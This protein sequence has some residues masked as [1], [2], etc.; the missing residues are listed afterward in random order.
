MR[1]LN[2]IVFINSAHVPYA[3]VKLDGNVHFIGTQGV[4]K[5]TLLRAVLFFYNADKGKLGIRTQDKQLGYDEFYLPYSNSYIIYEI[6]RENGKFFIISFRSQGR[7]A[8]RIVDCEYDKQFFV[9]DTGMVRE[10]WRE[11]RQRI[12]TITF[13]SDVIRSYE[14]FR[15]IIFGNTRNV[16]PEYRRF[17]ILES[18]RYQNIVRA[19]TNIFLNQSLESRVIKDTIIDS[20]DFADDYIDLE[21]YRERIKEFRN[22]YEDIWK[23]YKKEKDGSIKVRDQADNAIAEYVK[24]E[25]LRRDIDEL[26]GQ[27]L[28][29]LRRDDQELPKIKEEETALNEKLSSLRQRREEESKRHEGERDKLNQTEGKLKDFIKRL[30]EK[31]RHYAN[32]RI[33]EIITRIN[34]E[35]E[36]K[37]KNESLNNQLN[38]LTSANRGITDKYNAMI[39]EAETQLKGQINDTD[40]RFNEDLSSLNSKK[41]RLSEEYNALVQNIRDRKDEV[42]SLIQ[43]ELDTAREA[44]NELKMKETEILNSNPYKEEGAEIASKIDELKARDYELTRILAQTQREIDRIKHEA[45]IH[46][47]DLSANCEREVVELEKEIARWQTDIN[48][49]ND[50]LKN[51]EGSLMEWLCDNAPGWEENIGLLLDEEAV[52]Y[53]PDLK[54]HRIDNSCTVY[55][56]QLDLSRIDREVHSPK[57]LRDRISQLEGL[58]SNTK[59]RIAARKEKLAKDIEA[60]TAQPRK[61][62]K[63]LR[64]KELNLNGE[65]H[66][67]PS[68]IEKL[69]SGLTALAEKLKTWQD[70]EIKDIEEKKAEVDKK[71]TDI[72]SRK[73]KSKL[74]FEKECKAA[75]DTYNKKMNTFKKERDKIESDAENRKKSLKQE[76]GTKKRELTAAMDAELKGGGV[77]SKQLDELRKKIRAVDDALSF[78]EQHRRDYHGWLKDKDEYF[79]HESE[80]RVELKETKKKLA[81]LEEKFRVRKEKSDAE[82]KSLGVK[83]ADI[84]DRRQKI[85]NAIK[86]V[87]DF[88]KSD[89]C[90]KDIKSA[91]SIST[92]KELSEIY[93]AIH[94]KLLKRQ[95]CEEEFRKAVNVFKGNFTSHNTLGFETELSDLDDYRKFA[96]D[97]NEFISNGKIDIIF[98]RTNSLYKDIINRIAHE[99]GELIQHGADIRKTIS[100]INKDFRDNNFAGVIKEIELRAV[101]SNDRIMQQLM[102]IKKFGEE[103]GPEI[104]DFNLFTDFESVDATNDRAAKMIMTLCDLME[105]DNKRER[106]TLADT[107][108]L[109]FKVKQNDQDTNWVEKLSNVGSD[110]TD[111]LVKAIVNIMLINVFKRKASSRFG[112]FTLHCMMDEIGKLHPNNVQGILEFANARNIWLINSSPTTYNASAYKYTYSLSKDGMS[113]TIVKTLLT[114]K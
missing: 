30:E 39:R 12:G 90:P 58:I 55:G 79:D 52:L 60:A 110:G 85:E 98:K 11:I 112:D 31:K 64:E 83:I 47:K 35:D 53:N 13:K 97:L 41:D 113:H 34:S 3:E 57:S 103:H 38:L 101:E 37:I 104:G 43:E 72:R 29:A 100:E 8:F 93:D 61:E 20:M 22:R 96:S 107:F 66:T 4:G 28:Y 49:I 27:I 5:S 86:K 32:I 76:F 40:R 67:I 82:I 1:S 73:E 16:K 102:V 106:V 23:W 95:S 26:C 15:D 80:K 111:I 114:I 36:L 24:Y 44:A 65:L 105:A 14:E 63:S 50:L 46:E 6:E 33:E 7:A 68:R 42:D 81:D 108:K 21:S 19:I 45:E 74:R 2:K 94:T 75:A 109:E 9:D 17:N 89:S 18:D 62:L 69:K 54:P 71:M 10:D 48:R 70:S 25:D 78:I 88:M 84:K 91:K 92:H 99:V 51:Y 56:I 77:D 87:R 59:T